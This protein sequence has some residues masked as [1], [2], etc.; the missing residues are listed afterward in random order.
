MGA[1][2]LNGLDELFSFLRRNGTEEIMETEDMDKYHNTEVNR[3]AAMV[4][5]LVQKNGMACRRLR[6]DPN[7][8]RIGDWQLA[9]RKKSEKEW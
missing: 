8:K 4:Y 5:H 9:A 7:Y 2:N 6:W 1:S 3:R